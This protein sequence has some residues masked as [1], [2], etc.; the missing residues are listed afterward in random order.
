[1]RNLDYR[2]KKLIY[3]KPKEFITMQRLGLKLFLDPKNSVEAEGIEEI[4]TKLVEVFL[5]PGDIFVDVGAHLGW[6]STIAS[7]IV[8]NGGRVFAF[9][10]NHKSYALLKK[11]LAENKCINVTAENIAISDEK[12]HTVVYTVGDLWF[13]SCLLDPRK[14]P[15]FW[16][17]PH[18]SDFDDKTIYESE[19]P[20]ITLD[21]YLG[22]QRVDFVKIDT[23]GNDGKVLNGMKKLLNANPDIIIYMEFAPTLLEKFGTDPNAMIKNIREK[24]FN[25]F[26]T[27]GQSV[28]PF[29]DTNFNG[30]LFFTR[31]N[32]YKDILKL[33]GK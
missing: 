26:M 18:L 4:E 7:R 10:P 31:R 8:G 19:V 29:K 2:I 30:N 9:E 12:G 16:I 22:S 11:N 20:Q 17:T 3:G 23:E 1:M 24:G 32:I 27:D 33:K 6:F 21:E 25:V 5:R 14:D 15:D 28:K 13:G